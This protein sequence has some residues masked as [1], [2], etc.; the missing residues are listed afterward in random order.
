[1]KIN[2]KLLPIKG[3]Y[4]LFNAGTAPLVPY[5]S[6]YARQ[7]GFPAETVGLIYT[8]LPVCGLIAKPLFGVIADRF[9][10]QKLLFILFQV[11]TIVSFGAIYFIPPAAAPAAAPAVALGCEAGAVALRVCP[12]RPLLDSPHL[13]TP[14]CTVRCDMSSAAWRALCGA[15]PVR[16]RNA[17]LQDVG[18]WDDCPVSANGGRLELHTAHLR[19]DDR[20]TYLAVQH[21]RRDDGVLVLG[22]DACSPAA[23]SRYE[24]LPAACDLVC[25][26]IAPREESAGA[27]SPYTRQFGLFFALMIAS[28]VG[29]AVVV[30]FADAICFGV[31]GDR[32][33]LYGRQR[34]WGSLGWGVVSLLTGALVD[35]L[36]DGAVKDYTVAFALMAVFLAGD[37][38][39]SCVLRPPPPAPVGAGLAD[40]AAL[41][42]SAPHA[43]FAA[44]CTAA[45]LCTGL[46]WNFLFWHLEDVAADPAYVKTQQGLVS[47]VQTFGGEIPAMF[48]SGWVVRRA[49]HAAA[50]SVVLLAFGGRFLLY[51]ALRDAWWTLPVELLQGPT[52]GLLYPAMA[53]YAARAAPPGAATTVQGLAGAVFEGVGVSL[54]SLAGGQLYAAWGGAATFRWFG[55]GALAC[56][57]L[58]AGAARLLPAPSPPPPHKHADTD[59]ADTA[60]ALPTDHF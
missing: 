27:G 42:L 15:W 35:A 9:K 10:I 60:P 2:K 24:P 17:A 14:N 43:L 58:H 3:H 36:S 55:V 56:G 46:L 7:L 21:M 41:V 31:L 45:G 1:M 53:G 26:T 19:D 11:L 16:A 30:T 59:T 37:V 8:V 57:V 52:M 12:H 5:L 29:Q 32:A 13:Q 23:A 33:P 40:V 48:V 20:C 50:M 44:W 47:A 34:L 28:W 18:I 6:T 49:G 4:F 39:V 22:D 25:Y 38:A 54:G 51:S